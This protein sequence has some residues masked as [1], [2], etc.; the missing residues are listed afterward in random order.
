[1]GSFRDYTEKGPFVLLGMQFFGIMTVSIFLKETLYM[2]QLERFDNRIYHRKILA[3]GIPVVFQNFIVIGLNLIDTLMIGK[4]GEEPLA[5][6][7]VANQVYFI[8]SVSLFGFLSGSAVYTTQYFGAGRRDGVK[9]MLGISLISSLTLALLFVLVTY[10]FAP[11]IIGLFSQSHEVIGFGARYL[12]IAC[13]SYLFCAV[14]MVIS[15]K[16]RAVQDLNGVT[17]IN[18]IALCVN[19]VLNYILIYGKFGAPAMG[20]SGAALATLIARIFEAV[21]VWIF[22]QTKKTHWLRGKIKEYFSFDRKLF[23]GVMKMALPVMVTESIWSGSMALIFAAYGLLGTSALATAQ[24]ANVVTEMLQSFYFGVGNSTAMI[25]GE[26]VGKKELDIA[27]ECGKKA[28]RLTW[29]LNLVLGVLLILIAKP[30][31]GFYDFNED[32]NALI[33]RTIIVMAVVMAPKMIAYMYVV[34][35]LRAGG[36]TVF[37]MKLEFVFTMLLQVPTAFFGVLVLKLS[38]PGVIAL[39]AVIEITRIFIVRKRFRSG[40]WLNEVIQ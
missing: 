34:G 4:L 1:M 32:T 21:S 27:Y 17:V 6:I 22:I 33:V 25:I 29:I 16:S 35:I 2:S 5:A 28:M 30:I 7:G 11:E 36:D 18:F 40:I 24:I 20:V 9:M 31:T 10:T 13:F 19:A 37:C 39:S 8:F 26:Y 3:I 15:Y 12:R 23:K 38:L 14:S